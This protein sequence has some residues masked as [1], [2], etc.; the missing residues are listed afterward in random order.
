MF[1]KKIANNRFANRLKNKFANA[2]YK[3][4]WKKDT[5]FM[6]YLHMRYGPAFLLYSMVNAKARRNKL[7]QH[8]NDKHN[9][10]RR[11]FIKSYS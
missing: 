6:I 2:A 11:A 3:N 4:M 5:W 1:L 9:I 7:L 10:K 8:I